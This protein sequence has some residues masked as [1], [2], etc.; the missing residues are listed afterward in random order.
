[1]N[2]GIKETK[3]VVDAAVAI[4]LVVIKHAKDGFQVGKDSAAI[5]GELLS[6]DDVKAVIAKAV[7][8][9]KE[10]PAEIKDISGEEGVELAV[11]AALKVPAIISA[12]K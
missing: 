7:D 3:E 6:N 1:M 12:L 8:G 10:V 11:H 9:I 5:V 2:K 4:A